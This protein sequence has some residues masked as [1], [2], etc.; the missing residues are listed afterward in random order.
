MV[1]STSEAYILEE[2]KSCNV[3]DML[4]GKYTDYK[5]TQANFS[6]RPNTSNCYIASVAYNDGS[7][8]FRDV[9]FDHLNSGNTY[10]TVHITTR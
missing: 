8:R 9:S 10:E 4:A 6:L 2:G 7:S 3:S 5:G 1:L